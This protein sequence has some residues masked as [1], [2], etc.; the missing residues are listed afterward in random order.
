MLPYDNKSQVTTYRMPSVLYPSLMLVLD[1]EHARW[2]RVDE[3]AFE[4]IMGLRDQEEKHSQE[5]RKGDVGNTHAA[6]NMRRHISHVV[7]TTK[8]LW[9]AHG[10]KHLFCV[11]PSDS[12]NLL[13][14]E[15]K[16]VLPGA[17]MRVI[18]GNH[19]HEGAHKLHELFLAH[20]SGGV[21]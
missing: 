13:E 6:E 19:G 16:K 10:F 2:F 4:E 3:N 9:D 8:E 20:R 14:D 7:T 15:L 21:G 1:S 12:K 5:E 11:E 18:V 17:D